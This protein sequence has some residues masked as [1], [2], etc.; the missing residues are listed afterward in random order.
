M[1][2][3]QA[4]LKYR[5]LEKVQSREAIRKALPT[6]ADLLTFWREVKTLSWPGSFGSSPWNY[7]CFI[8]SMASGAEVTNEAV[9]AS[10]EYKIAM[11]Y[12]AER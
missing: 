5:H 9:I 12:A 1:N 3:H 10:E 7:C 11:E 8:A 4:A 6:L 2:N